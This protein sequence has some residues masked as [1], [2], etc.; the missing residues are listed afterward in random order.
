MRKMRLSRLIWS[1][2]CLACLTAENAQS[3]P[4]KRTSVSPKDMGAEEIMSDTKPAILLVDDNRMYR[5]SVRRNLEFE[6][7]RVIEAQ[8]KADALDKLRDRVPDVI[9]TDLDIKTPTEGLDLIREVKNLYPLIPIILISA[10]GTFDE[11]ALAREYGAAYVI[12]K[13]RIDAEI[14]NLYR[15]IEKT[16]AVMDRTRA[17]KDRFDKV[18]E[19][20]DIL[21][22]LGAYRYC[23]DFTAWGEIGN[24]RFYRG[25]VNDGVHVEMYGG[26]NL[27]MDVTIRDLKIMEP[28]ASG[29]QVTAGTLIPS[30]E[31]HQVFGT[32]MI[33]NVTVTDPGANGINFTVDHTEVIGAKSRGVLEVHDMAITGV[34]VGIQASELIGMVYDTVIT[35]TMGPAVDLRYSTF[36]FFSCDVGPVDITNIRVLT[37]GAARMWYDLGV[38]AA[39]RDPITPVRIRDP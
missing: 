19:D 39:R 1:S 27:E 28:G 2:L 13:S 31:P 36:D 6:D 23:D 11:G 17:L 12:S 34:A 25:Y 33:D 7:Y 32:V 14:D 8:D 18:V 15:L 24:N 10:V 4:S 29:I 30:N 9:I 5:E 16:L 26:W 35:D 37:K 20:E 21:F 22:R 3:R 38:R